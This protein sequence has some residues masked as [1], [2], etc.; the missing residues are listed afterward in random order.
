M[1]KFA[2]GMTAGIVIGS[3]GL[4]ALELIAVVALED[5]PEVR[6]EFMDRLDK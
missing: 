5:S 1:L 3:V 2:L 4:F 6:K